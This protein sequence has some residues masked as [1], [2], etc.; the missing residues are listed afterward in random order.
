MV[1]LF[2]FLCHQ[3]EPTDPPRG[4]MN[5]LNRVFSGRRVRITQRKPT[6]IGGEQTVHIKTLR[7][8]WG[9]NPEPSSCE[10]GVLNTLAS[11]G[12]F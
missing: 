11:L 2:L 6:Q 12:F 7:L 9:S 3:V 1:F 10:A 4:G 8:V 5:V